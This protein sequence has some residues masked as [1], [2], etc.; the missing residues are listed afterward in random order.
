MAKC[1]DHCRSIVVSDVT[2]AINLLKSGKRDGRKDLY[3]DN[4]TWPTF[5]L[6]YI[7]NII[8]HFF[9]HQC[10]ITIMLWRECSRVPW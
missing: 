6:L 7:Y 9:L 5:I 10:Y 1:I 3:T 2:S 4:D 8:Y